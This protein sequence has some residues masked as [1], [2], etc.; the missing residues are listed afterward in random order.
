[1]IKIDG[2]QYFLGCKRSFASL[3]LLRWK[4]SIFMIDVVKN[5][6]EVK[7]C[8][9]I[10]LRCV[11]VQKSISFLKSFRN[12]NILYA[13]FFRVRVSPVKTIGI[14]GFLEMNGRHFLVKLLSIP[15]AYYSENW[16]GSGRSEI[17]I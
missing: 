12:K 6:Y 16:L 17:I 10:I 5:V 15:L 3:K 8:F 13:C 1:M 2:G 14:V 4:T 7:L 11:S 9:E